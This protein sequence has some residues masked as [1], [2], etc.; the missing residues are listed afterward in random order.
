MGDNLYTIWNWSFYILTVE[1]DSFTH[2]R[3]VLRLWLHVYPLYKKNCF[4]ANE[5]IKYK[6]GNSKNLGI[7]CTSNPHLLKA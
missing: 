6:G 2:F 1:P 4:C 3:P 5:D 7:T